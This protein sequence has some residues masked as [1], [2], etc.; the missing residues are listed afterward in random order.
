M[1]RLRLSLMLVLGSMSAG[2]GG[3]PKPVELVAYEHRARAQYRSTLEV[4]Q[5]ELL[6]RSRAAHQEAIVA[7][8]RKDTDAVI[9]YTRLADIHWRTAEA[10]S[11]TK[12]LNDAGVAWRRQSVQH[13]QS[14]GLA[15]ERLAAVERD[16]RRLERLKTLRSELVNVRRTARQEKQ[17]AAARQQIDAAMK[18][19]R[20]AELLDAERHAPGALNKARQSLQN[21]FDAFN[22][23]RYADAGKASD[24]ALADAAEAA[25]AARP[26]HDAEAE[27]RAVD[28][29]LRK[30]LEEIAPAPWAD[31]RIEKRGLVVSLRELFAPKKAR[32]GRTTRVEPVAALAQGHARF[33]I[34]IEGHTDNRGPPK[35]NS[36]LSAARAKAIAGVLGEMGVDVKRLSVQGKGDAEPVAD[37]STARG[38]GL[39]RRVDVVFLRPSMVIGDPDGTLME[40]EPIGAGVAAPKLVKPDAS[41]TAQPA[42]VEGLPPTPANVV[43]TP[44]DPAPD[45]SAGIAAPATP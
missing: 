28:G 36:S 45:G 6:Q 1:R 19:M 7:W 15:D 25:D 26:I 14:K 38:R 22:A 35:E 2:C 43:D 12:D 17:A 4:R 23:G 34:I 16:I 27:Q 29:E 31:A 30:M 10:L 32:L 24:F 37:N 5:P 40:G 41:T 20:T 39:N 42:P 21:A 3:T 11:H 33:S 13:A 9:H 18:Q 8:R 44:V